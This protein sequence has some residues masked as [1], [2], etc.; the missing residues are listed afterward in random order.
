MQDI[1]ENVRPV[2]N[3]REIDIKI[4]FLVKLTFGYYESDV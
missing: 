2:F 4:Y 1:W 3:F